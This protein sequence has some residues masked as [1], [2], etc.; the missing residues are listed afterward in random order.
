[1]SWFG[2]ETSNSTV[3]QQALPDIIIQ[4]LQQQQIPD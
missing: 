4:I 2:M 1:M 3:K